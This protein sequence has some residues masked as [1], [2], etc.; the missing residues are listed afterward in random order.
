MP[1]DMYIHSNFGLTVTG[2]SVNIKRL[3]IADVKWK[4]DM[5]IDFIDAGAWVN[6]YSMPVIDAKI[7][8]IARKKYDGI[9]QATVMLLNF[10]QF[11]HGSV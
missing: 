9:C 2:I 4:S 11:E 8:E 1:N 3:L 10:W 5:T 6:A 7:S